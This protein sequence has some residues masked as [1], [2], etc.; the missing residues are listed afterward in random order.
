[1]T[2]ELTDWEV[3]S[4]CYVLSWARVLCY[5]PGLVKHRVDPRLHLFSKVIIPV[6]VFYR[7]TLISVA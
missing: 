6:T 2:R 4:P 7:L 5:L 1:M 3:V